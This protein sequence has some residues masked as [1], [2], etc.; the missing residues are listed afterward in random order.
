VKKILSREG[1]GPEMSRRNGSD[2]I[3]RK[4]RCDEDGYWT[5]ES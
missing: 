1:G 3:G 2:C 5:A 4:S